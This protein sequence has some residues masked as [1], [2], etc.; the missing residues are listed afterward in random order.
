MNTRNGST[1]AKI[2]LNSPQCHLLAAP[3]LK[4]VR[5]S[6]ISICKNKMKD[7]RA[8]EEDKEEDKEEEVD[9]ANLHILVHSDRL[10][11]KE[12]GDA[13]RWLRYQRDF[14]SDHLG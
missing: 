14:H 8:E 11:V 2:H 13:R 9:V 1:S 10:V 5:V 12:P 4:L 7:E 3:I 6:V